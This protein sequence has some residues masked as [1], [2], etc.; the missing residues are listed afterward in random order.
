[1]SRF[2]LILPRG[3]ERFLLIKCRKKNAE[4]DS[5]SR[6]II[7]FRMVWLNMF[8]VRANYITSRYHV[9]VFKWKMHARISDDKLE[10]VSSGILI[11]NL[12]KRLANNVQI[13]AS[14]VR[15]K[16]LKVTRYKLFRRQLHVPP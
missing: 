9:S 5:T 2:I 13:V 6:T 8:Y 1:M 12:R 10:L 14:Q 15:L 16:V 4:R 11:V 7:A 3:G